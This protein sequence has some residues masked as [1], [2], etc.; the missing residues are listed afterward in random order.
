M[1]HSMY[2]LNHYLE[3]NEINKIRKEK[4]EIYK[5]TVAASPTKRDIAHGA[6]GDRLRCKSSPNASSKLGPPS[7]LVNRLNDGPSPPRP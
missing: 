5:I 2:E 3:Q 6:A 1:G 4:K 7:P